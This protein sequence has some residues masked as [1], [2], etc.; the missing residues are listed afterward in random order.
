MYHINTCRRRLSFERILNKNLHERGVVERYLLDGQVG[1]S[2]DVYGEGI[3][4]YEVSCRPTRFI[5]N[6]YPTKLG[7]FFGRMRYMSFRISRIFEFPAI[8]SLVRGINHLQPGVLPNVN[9]SQPQPVAVRRPLPD[10]VFP[11]M[12]FFYYSA[13][14]D[15]ANLQNKAWDGHAVRRYDGISRSPMAVTEMHDTGI[16]DELIDLNMDP[17][18]PVP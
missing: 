8:S 3:A 5:A 6:Y 12:S 15:T 14:P 18:I 16:P 13:C 11:W 4:L 10:G 9:V 17:Q 2:Q 1:S 7:P